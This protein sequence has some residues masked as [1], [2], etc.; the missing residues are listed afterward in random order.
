MEIIVY[1]SLFLTSSFIFYIFYDAVLIPKQVLKERLDNVKVMAD[2]RDAFDEEMR[3][4]FAER[5]IDPVYER[6]IQALGNLAPSSI[7]KQYEQLLSSSGTRGTM[8]FNNIIAIQLMLGLLLAFGTHFLMRLTEQPTNG[9]YV[10]LA[11]AAGFL[12]PYSSLK[13]KSRKRIEAIEYALPSFLDVLYV[14][15]EAGLAFDMAIYRTTDKMKGPLSEELLFTMNEISK[16]RGR[17]EALRE[18]VK[19][20]QVPD[21]ATFVTSI[22][23]AEEMGSNIGNVLRIQADT[24][25]VNKRQRAET[26][27]AKIPTKMLFPIVFFMFPALFVVILGPAVLNIMETL[28]K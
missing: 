20:T 13:T 27:A 12:L 3:E 18:M 24:M 1:V 4:S 6:M 14:S 7:K 10:V 5:V 23:Q 19:R 28:M 2:T 11:G 15:V 26:M 9:I 17:S 21:L 8:K 25:R 22:I 16:G